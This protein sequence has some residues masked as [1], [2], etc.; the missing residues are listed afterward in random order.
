VE[1]MW[2]GKRCAIV[3]GWE[4]LVDMAKKPGICSYSFLIWI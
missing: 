3:G 4:D 2:D 1:E